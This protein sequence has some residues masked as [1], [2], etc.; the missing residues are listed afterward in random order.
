MRGEIPAILWT[1][2]EARVARATITRYSRWLVETRGLEAE[3]YHDLW[4]GP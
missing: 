3:S 1:P 4:R 2:D